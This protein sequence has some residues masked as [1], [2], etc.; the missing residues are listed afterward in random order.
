M[1]LSAEPFAWQRGYGVFTLGESQR[2]RAEAYVHNQKEHHR[3]QTTNQW[4]EH[5]DE[6]DEPPPDTGLERKPTKI[7]EQLA[8]YEIDDRFP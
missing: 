1:N 5:M 3:Q 2:A 8:K 4:L 6:S 7:G